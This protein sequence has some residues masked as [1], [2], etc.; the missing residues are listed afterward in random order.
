[1]AKVGDLQIIA[2]NDLILRVEA[3]E[4]ESGH[5]LEAESGHG[6]VLLPSKASALAAGFP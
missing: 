2:D 6:S 4:A 1:M 3:V 5:G